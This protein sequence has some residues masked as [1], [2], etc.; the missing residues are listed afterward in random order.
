MSLFPLSLPPSHPLP[1]GLIPPHPLA[2]FPFSLLELSEML[3]IG[4][5]WSNCS[6]H[7]F[8]QPFCV[9]IGSACDRPVNNSFSVLIFRSFLFVLG[10]LMQTTSSKIWEAERVKLWGKVK[11]LT[12]AHLR[13]CFL[14]WFPRNNQVFEPRGLWSIRFWSEEK[15]VWLSGMFDVGFLLLLFTDSVS[16]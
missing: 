4:L 10:L 2:P 15:S 14:L 1:T 5:T 8:L 11:F 13:N 16:F 9:L 3:V 12:R 6:V 7:Y